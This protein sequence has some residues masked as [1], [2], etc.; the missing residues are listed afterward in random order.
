MPEATT[1]NENRPRS[2]GSGA[3]FLCRGKGQV[4]ERD[5]GASRQGWRTV[6]EMVA[7]C[8]GGSS[9][10]HDEPAGVGGL[11]EPVGYQ[12][13]WWPKQ[14]RK[15]SSRQARE[16]AESGRGARPC[17]R[18]ASWS[19]SAVAVGSVLRVWR[20]TPMRS[21]LRARAARRRWSSAPARRGSECHQLESYSQ[22]RCFSG[23]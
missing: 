8:S 12:K 6:C 15:S 11:S 3:G 10:Q 4:A 19:K 5:G 17:R 13:L 16:R 23:Q 18:W 2:F 9:R 1:C 20:A 14:R 7:G 22:A 21:S